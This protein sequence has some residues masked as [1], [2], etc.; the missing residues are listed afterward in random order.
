LRF[1]HVKAETAFAASEWHLIEKQPDEEIED[2]PGMGDADVL[3]IAERAAGD[4]LRHSTGLSKLAAIA[5]ANHLRQTNFSAPAPSQYETVLMKMV[6]VSNPRVGS[7]EH[8]HYF[9]LR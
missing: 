2:L 5:E 6:T 3:G 4:F 8:H 9:A 1:P 7:V